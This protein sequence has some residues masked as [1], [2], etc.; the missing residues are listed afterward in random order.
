MIT[1]LL[2]E[3]I[4]GYGWIAMPAG[5]P[6]EVPAPFEIQTPKGD[7]LSGVIVSSDHEFA[8]GQASF[9]RRHAE[10]DGCLNVRVSRTGTILAVGYGMVSQLS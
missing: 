5:T 1:L 9:S 7:P 10:D 3:P 2:I 8:G 6:R 4:Y